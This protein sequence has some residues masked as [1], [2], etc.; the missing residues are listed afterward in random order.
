MDI[1]VITG[2]SSGLGREYLSQ[3]V[4]QRPSTD[5][6]WLI[7]RRQERLQELAALYPDVKIRCVPLDLQ[8]EESF[9]AYADLLKEHNACVKLLI[10]NAGYGKLGDFSKGVCH[11]QTGMV[12]LNCRALTAMTSLSLPHMARGSMI[13]NVCSIAAFAPTPRMA[14]YCS[15]K[16][17]VYSLSKALR[18]ELR[19]DGIHVLAVCPGPMS[20][21]FLEVADITGRSKTFQ[22]L[23]YCDPK[24]VAAVSLRR[25]RRGKGIYTNRLFFKFYRFLAKLLPHHLVMYMSKT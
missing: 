18:H 7:A 11:E 12:D 13:L 25:L 17:Y 15:T 24:T 2:A 9:A 8:K 14:V 4:V 3:V 23:P 21:E 5:E 20:T 10:N 19:P 6:I 16:A 1:T 22:R